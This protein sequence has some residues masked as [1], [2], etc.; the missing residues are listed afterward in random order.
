MASARQGDGRRDL[1]GVTAVRSIPAAR[2][3][4]PRVPS[5]S[6]PR[7]RLE[8]RLGEDAGLPRDSALVCAPVG[9]GK[10]TLVSEWAGGLRRAGHVVAWVSCDARD[11]VRGW[12]ATV[13][14]AVAVG[15][16]RSAVPE[17]D[18]DDAR[19]WGDLVPPPGEVE[20][21]FVAEVLDRLTVDGRPAVL[22]L[23]D[24]HAV[25]DP[26]VRTAVDDLLSVRPPALRLVLVGRHDPLVDVHG[27]RLSGRLVEL[28]AAD[29]ACTREESARL[30]GAYG[31]TLS[32]GSTDLLHERTEGWPAGLRL[33]SLCLEH[34]P[35]PDEAVL[36]FT[37]DTRI[38]ADYLMSSV[39]ARLP[40]DE[41]R[42]LRRTSILTEV[43][44]DL[45]DAVTGSSRSAARLHH[46]ERRN[47]L[48]VRLGRQGRWYRYH[49]MLREYL[50]ADL[51]VQD[52]D[53]HRQLHLR[54]AR[55]YEDDGQP[56]AALRH[57]VASRDPGAAL[58]QLR[59]TGVHLFVTGDGAVVARALEAL[60]PP[61][62][63]SATA[64]LLRALLAL[65]AG[66]TARAHALLAEEAQDAGDDGR[67]A[68]DDDPA[69]P[70]R[71]D[72][73]L[74]V[75]AGLWRRRVDGDLSALTPQALLAHLDAGLE[76]DLAA[77]TALQVGP[78]LVG[79]DATAEA[80]RVLGAALDHAR[81]A[82]NA[83]LELECLNRL[84]GAA[85]AASDLEGTRSWATAAIAVAE[86]RGWSSS[87]RL[88]YAYGLAAWGCHLGAQPE[89][90]RRLA[91]R[92]VAVLRPGVDPEVDG[93]ARCVEAVVR[94]D[95]PSG[96]RAA[97]D[98]LR[99]WWVAA[100]GLDVS[101]ALVALAGLGELHACLRSGAVDRAAEV[102]RRSGSRLGAD[103]D[104]AVLAA[105]LDLACGRTD[106]AHRRVREA[107]H[108]GTALVTVTCRLTAHLVEAVAAHRQGRTAAAEAAVLDGVELTARTGCVRPFVDLRRDVRDVLVPLAGRAGA[109]ESTL[110]AVLAS[111]G[112]EEAGAEP[113]ALT[114][115]ERD[116][117]REL[118]SLL[119]LDEIAERHQVSVNTVKSHVRTLYRKLGVSSRRDAVTAA[120]RHGLV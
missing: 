115:R 68:A 57:A 55:W 92:A 94:A 48:V 24:V 98:D 13:V 95:A 114:Q 58:E 64:R 70:V 91:G 82:G 15:V 1:R 112:A 69:A 103:G 87:P 104:A 17:Q 34:E 37:A 20:A 120:R 86:R 39:L 45:A 7:P 78:L 90:A 62:A 26:A 59:R 63:R 83:Y 40:E 42:F 85:A 30:L 12:W 29:L 9:Y 18:A 65:D 118:P 67:G 99:R 105:V 36:R 4:L 84:A 52:P 2:V 66:E 35:D 54:A 71:S 38:V 75:T 53:G 50:E 32:A 111:L 102:V 116:M 100:E 10:T 23:D 113:P 108:E 106:D 96:R 79:L 88:A 97:L 27:L 6:V 19:W 81:A 31:R 101:R 60:P 21:A 77:L 49:S 33:A 107:L 11:D 43:T 73:H 22:V 44:A 89:E 76:P 14:A 16:A 51:R 41:H 25:E 117:L 46:L 80:R 3:S 93:A 5:F 56:A 61:A 72:A 109:Q 8:A 119:Q 74:R 47:A 110:G 28:R